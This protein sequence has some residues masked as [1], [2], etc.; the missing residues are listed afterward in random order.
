MARVSSVIEC[1]DRFFSS[2]ASNKLNDSHIHF[3]IL[4]AVLNSKPSGHT[5]LRSGKLFVIGIRVPVPERIACQYKA[6]LALALVLVL[7]N[8]GMEYA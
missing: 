8:F 5:Q 1:L 2:S 7:H 4:Q 3:S 6:L